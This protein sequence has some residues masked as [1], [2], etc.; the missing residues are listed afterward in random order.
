VSCGLE[1]DF[2]RI[3]LAGAGASKLGRLEEWLLALE[4]SLEDSYRPAKIL[5]INKL[6][7]NN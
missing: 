5:K 1:L 3:P 6:L 4:A 7:L 2:L